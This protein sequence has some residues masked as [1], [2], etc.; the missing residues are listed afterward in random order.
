[1][2]ARAQAIFL[3][4]LTCTITWWRNAEEK[5]IHLL[6]YHRV[7]MTLVIEPLDLYRHEVGWADDYRHRSKEGGSTK[8]RTGTEK[9]RRA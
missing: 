8:S 7:G 2:L 6:A 1:M 3:S 9:R 5:R 4:P